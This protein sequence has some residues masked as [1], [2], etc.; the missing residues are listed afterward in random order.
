[1]HEDEPLVDALVKHMQDDLVSHVIEVK[2][3][4]VNVTN[5]S[6]QGK[7]D[8]CVVK[9]N[10]EDSTAKSMIATVPGTGEHRVRNVSKKTRVSVRPKVVPSLIG[11]K[12]IARLSAA[13]MNALIRSLK[14]SKSSKRNSVKGNSTKSSSKNSSY[15]VHG[16][17]LSAGSGPSANSKDW[18]NWV[19]LHG[20][21]KVE[22]DD[23]IDV[24]KAIGIHCNNSFQV[25]S[26]GG[27]RGG[28]AGDGEARE[29]RVVWALCGGS[30]VWMEAMKIIS[31]NIRGLG[32][33]VKKREIRRL[34]V[35]KKPTVLCIQETKLE[36]VDEFLCRSLWGTDPMSFSF[37]SS[38]GASGGIITVWDPS[39]V[40]VWLSVNIANCLIIKG[41]LL[42][43]NE[44]FCLAN[45]YAPCEG[46]GRQDLWDALTNLFQL[47]SEAAWCFLGDFN[48]VRSS[49]ER[50]GRVE[51]NVFGDYAPFNQF[52]DGNFLVDL[53]L[54]GRNF[55][56]YRGDGV[57][58]SRLD[59]FLLSESWMVMFPNCIQVA[60]P[61]GLSDHCPLLLTIDEDSWGP[62]PFRMLKCWADIPG[63]G[64][65]VKD[66]WHSLQV[67]GWSGFILKEKL[68]KIKESLRSWHLNHT[69]N[70]D[71]QI[72]GAKARLAVL[73]TLGEHDS[74]G[75]Q[76]VA[77]LHMLSADIMAF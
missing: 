14:K 45:V 62:N 7:V 41:T 44:V 6:F 3:A 13:N 67:Q 74:L 12:K 60:L 59:R 22:E 37:K 21:A 50:R 70:I 11:L 4:V 9:E 24:V 29:V 77:E 49:D 1:L 64:D 34:V 71:S 30:G 47:H 23:I 73:D 52:I 2:D 17:S 26:R 35:E 33:V 18:E 56:W 16:V 68:K 76:E 38:V 27:V 57:S 25:L 8:L 42:Q 5:Q 32:A 10:S 43:N 20:D 40:D 61:R 58:M 72:H 28:A 46:K 51:N 48:A 69:L 63:Y 36:V 54:C 15:K 55:T 19:A 75:D 66:K 65:F 31:I 53:P 39:L